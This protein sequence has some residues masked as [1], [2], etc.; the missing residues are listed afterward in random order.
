MKLNFDAAIGDEKTS[1]AL[2][3]RDD[4][5]VLLTAWAEQIDPGSPILGDAKAALCAIRKAIQEDYKKV[6]V[7]GDAWNV[8]EPLINSAQQPH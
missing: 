2:V 4:K 6:I 3:C 8:I 1:I 7:E 5:G